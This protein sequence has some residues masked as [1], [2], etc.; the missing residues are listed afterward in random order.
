[1]KEPDARMIRHSL[2]IMFVWASLAVLLHGAPLS[3][4]PQTLVQPN[5][6]TIRVFASG[7]E[8]YSWVHDKDNFT[9]VRDPVSGA[10]VYAVAGN[11]ALHPSPYRVGKI[12]PHSVGLI[13]GVNVYPD[14]NRQQALEK[15]HRHLSCRIRP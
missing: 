6:D 14:M 8:F 13:Q 9:I 1:M 12:D 11:G 10:Y 4:V 5:G 3:F 7:D 2:Y 15:I